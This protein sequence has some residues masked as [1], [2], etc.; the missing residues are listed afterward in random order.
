[1]KKLGL[2]L[3][4]VLIIFSYYLLD[5]Y[6][7]ILKETFEASDFNIQILTSS[8]DFDQDGLDDYSDFVLGAK[9]DAD[10][11]P[12]YDGSYV[13]G[14]Y[15]SDDVGVCT[16][17]IW[18]AFKEAGYNLK[19]MIDLDIQNNR[20]D[21]PHINQPDP[22][23]DFRRV[24]NLHIFFKKYGTTLPLESSK[25]EQWQPGDIIIF[26][27][28]DHIGL[29]SDKRNDKGIVLIYHNGGQ[30]NRHE[31]YLKRGKVIG[32]YRFDSSLVDSSI[33]IPWQ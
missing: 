22:N 16:D 9:K 20:Q 19:E 10:N 12:R 13:S 1:M 25:I 24:P 14:G 8:I 28:N 15:P 11:H 33:L 4:L 26:N 2:I 3:I 18:R 5:R 6:N 7:L 23:I 31:D 30:P 17:V 32:H 21:Y 29:V 27:N